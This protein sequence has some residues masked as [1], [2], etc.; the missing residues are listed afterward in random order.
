MQKRY[1][2]E[3][4][5]TH[6]QAWKDSGLTQAA[7]CEQHEIKSSSFK[8]WGSCK[9][10]AQL[11]PVQISTPVVEP[12][13]S[14]SWYGSQILLPRPMTAKDWQTLLFAIKALSI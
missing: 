4:K 13:I 2:T 7:Y 12:A 5:A 1:S 8:N 6:W 10:K 14:I 3:E 11:I 9:P